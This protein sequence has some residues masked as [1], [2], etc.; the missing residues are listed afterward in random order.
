MVG[1]VLMHVRVHDPL[2][3]SVPALGMLAL[4]AFVAVG[5]N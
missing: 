4:S 2:V 5:A 1:A 3:R